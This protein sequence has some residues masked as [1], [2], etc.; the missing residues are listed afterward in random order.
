MSDEARVEEDRAGLRY[1]CYLEAYTEAR[2]G[3]IVTAR[4]IIEDL[5]LRT[6]FAMG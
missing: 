1:L 2:C 5:R 3:G 6:L 4:K